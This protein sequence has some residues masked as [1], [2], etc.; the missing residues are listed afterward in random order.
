MDDILYLEKSSLFTGQFRARFP[1]FSLEVVSEDSLFFPRLVQV[2]PLVIL[3]GDTGCVNPEELLFCLRGLKGFSRIPAVLLGDFEFTS[4]LPVSHRFS[5]SED[6]LPELEAALTDL[7]NRG[8]K[9]LAGERTEWPVPL[10][11][12]HPGFV[13]HRARKLME[14]RI[15]EDFLE[16]ELT[17]MNMMD[18]SFDQVLQTLQEKLC[19]LLLLDFVYLLVDA[20][21]E[22]YQNLY[23]Y[24]NTSREGTR[25]ITDLCADTVPAEYREKTAQTSVSTISSA[26]KGKPENP[27]P[28]GGAVLLQTAL[29]FSLGLSGHLVLGR[30][31]G[32][33][34]K[35]PPRL[36][37]QIPSLCAQVLE[38]AFIYYKKIDETQVIFRAFTQF[39][40]API[41]NDLLLKQSERA[42]MTGEKRRI[43]V[44]FSHIR[45]FDH[46]VE[47][48]QPEGV[49]GFLNAHFTRM[50]KIIQDHGGIIDKF[51]GD[52]VFAI[53]GAPISYRD[54][55][56]RAAAAAVRMIETYRDLDLPGFRFPPEGF[57]IGVG[58]N[59]GQAII[60]NIGCADKFDY[61]AIGDT[62]NLAA[63]LESLT[64][65]YH[66][67]IL[68]S[69]V[70]YDQIRK[71]RY[72]RLID[73]AKVKGKSESTDIYSLVVNPAPYTEKWRE[74]YN[75]GLKMY[76]LG[77]WR[78]AS[79]YF[80][81]AQKILP[82]D[83][84]CALLLDRCEQFQAEPPENWDGAVALNFK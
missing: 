17:G 47:N 15:S 76:T 31:E 48:N 6:E 38:A 63:R 61:T 51:I 55:T 13:H 22:F 28:G 57:S 4:I 41:I 34:V 56:E 24:G 29:P 33:Q 69:R 36:K 59:E 9:E 52:A 45:H 67:D 35:L 58:L 10:R 23:I 54:N 49:V 11:I 18:L 3:L 19:R 72:C 84:V 5:R 37:E 40:P 25:K 12:D 53:F 62:V 46:M 60:G 66:Q 70:V 43:V 7:I 39:L 16:S 81:A 32:D 14:T 50:V 8:R 30:R 1:R 42:L 65:H 2:R 75:R 79:D 74:L 64:K 44:L 77:N 68:I 71:T 73:R 78:T 20:H 21:R 26:V 27:S 82:D 80:E 83:F